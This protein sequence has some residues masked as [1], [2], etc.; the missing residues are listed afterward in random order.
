MLNRHLRGK[1]I[2]PYVAL[3]LAPILFL[4]IS[5]EFFEQLDYACYLYSL[6]AGS[7]LVKPAERER[8]DFLRAVFSLKLFRLIRVSENGLLVLP[9]AGYL[10]Y[11]TEWELALALLLVGVAMALFSFQSHHS[12]SLPTPFGKQPFEFPAGFRRSFFL[13]PI[14]YFLGYM[15]ISVDNLNLGV[16]AMLL[17]FIVCMSYYAKPEPRYYVWIFNTRPQQF[18][19]DKIVTS[20]KYGGA[21]SLPMV[22]ALVIFFPEDFDLILLFVLL[23]GLYLSAVILAKYAAF[24]KKMDLTQGVLLGLSVWFPPLIL[25]VIPWFYSRSIEKLKDVLQ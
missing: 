20:L 12:F 16:G 8:N 3:L 22:I 9:F 19:K 25:A 1:L 14:A 10:V 23:A 5:H 21:L 15:S 4:A 17:I 7:L 11:Q 18:L 2:N 24:P 13:F 6:L